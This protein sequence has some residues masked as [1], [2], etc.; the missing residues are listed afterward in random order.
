MGFSGGQ[1]EYTSLDPNVLQ[2][3]LAIYRTFEGNKSWF[4][5]VGVRCTEFLSR[6]IRQKGNEKAFDIAGFRSIP[7]N[8]PCSM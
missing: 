7:G 2:S 8:I 5:I 4:D 3:D 6:Q 1:E